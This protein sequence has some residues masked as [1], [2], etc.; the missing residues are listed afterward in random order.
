MTNT[1]FN[2]YKIAKA[3]A[4]AEA[5]AAAP[6]PAEDDKKDAVDEKEKEYVIDREKHDAGIAHMLG[7]GFDVSMADKALIMAKGMDP[8]ARTSLL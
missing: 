2:A 3:K 4:K 5:E 6:P 1:E 7:M 8:P